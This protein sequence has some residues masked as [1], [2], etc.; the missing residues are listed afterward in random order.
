MPPKTHSS[1]PPAGKR[2]KVVA[3]P[4][5]T[6]AEMTCKRARPIASFLKIKDYAKVSWPSE[7]VQIHRLH[8]MWGGV[9]VILI[10]INFRLPILLPQFMSSATLSSL[11]ILMEA[12]TLLLRVRAV[13][14]WPRSPHPNSHTTALLH[15]PSM[16]PGLEEALN[17]RGLNN[18]SDH[19]SDCLFVSL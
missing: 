11:Q 9:L 13:R 4:A 15:S 1:L 2:S 8:S 12:T 5:Q 14:L 10:H 7:H 17:E 16:I 19:Y 3:Y 18:P 6:L